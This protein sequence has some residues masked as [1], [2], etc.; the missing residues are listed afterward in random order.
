VC[1]A[2]RGALRGYPGSGI[3][4]DIRSCRAGNC[5][6]LNK[7]FP[8]GIGDRHFTKRQWTRKG[9]TAKGAYRPKLYKRLASNLDRDK[10]RI[11]CEK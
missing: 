10:D 6:E 9:A 4:E 1:A 5:T 2:D 8:H 11:A 3:G 7:R